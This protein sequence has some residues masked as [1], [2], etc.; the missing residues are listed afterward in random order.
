M[1]ISMCGS[2]SCSCVCS[3]SCS[4]VCSCVCS[5]SCSSV[6]SCVC[7]S[8]GSASCSSVGSSVCSSVDSGSS[9]KLGKSGEDWKYRVPIDDFSDVVNLGNSGEDFGNIASLSMT[10]VICSLPSFPS[11]P[12]REGDEQRTFQARDKFSVGSM[13][14]SQSFV[15][16]V[17]HWHAA[18]SWHTCRYLG[19]FECFDLLG[20]NSLRQCR[21]MCRAVTLF[22]YLGFRT[23]G[24]SPVAIK[25]L[26]ALTFGRISTI[27]IFQ[28]Q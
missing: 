21:R 7:S 23:C 10:L 20:S 3:A 19:Y 9:E 28:F 8:V 26:F 1:I 14:C 4:S 16:A 25:A 13:V 18:C 27:G 5:A 6:C 11:F 24:A 15:H 2:A 22:L 17:N 12:A